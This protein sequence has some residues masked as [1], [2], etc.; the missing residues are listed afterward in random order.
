MQKI[1]ISTD[2]RTDWMAIL[3]IGIVACAATWYFASFA[4]E[5]SL[6]DGEYHPWGYDSFY[7]AAL[8]RDIVDN[9]PTTMQFDDHLHPL[10]EPAAVSFTWAYTLLLA[11][12]VVLVQQFASSL[13]TS[14]ILAYIP[15][16]WGV[17]NCLVFIALC[18]KAGLRP[19][20]LALA[21]AG[22]ALAPYTRD[23][24]MIGNVDHHFMELFFILTIMFGFYNWIESPA[25]TGRAVFS[26][27]VL[28]LSVAFHFALFVMYLPIALFF[29]ITWI[30]DR[31]ELKAAAPAFLASVLLATLIAVLPSAQFPVLK[32]E[33]FKLGWFHLYWAGVFCAAVFFL[34]RRRYTP[35]NLAI[36][37]VFLIV[38]AIPLA[39]NLL[40]GTSFLAAELPGF[41][42][43]NETR[44][45]FAYLFSGDYK[46]VKQ[47]YEYYSGLIYAV[48]FVLILLVR[49]VR[50]TP[51]PELIYTLCAF[52]LGAAFL[53]LQLRFKYH[54]SYVLL[55][56]VLLLFQQYAA[57]IRF[58][59]ALAI[60][61]F[62][63]FYAGP[64]SKLA[65]SQPPGGEP[66]YIS[67]LPFLKV[68]SKQCAAHPGILLAHPDE[69]HYLRYHTDCKILSSNML[70]ESRDFEYRALALKML[71]M[72]V[73]E[74]MRKYDWL[75]YIYARLE[76]GPGGNFDPG[77]LRSLNEGVREELLL[78]NNI[79]PGTKSL[80][81]SATP[82]FTY[83]R[84]LQVHD[85]W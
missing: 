26:G 30:S 46:L 8:V 10:H 60:I 36:L 83:Q 28:G 58:P 23:L 15:P 59:K 25:S 77:Y 55:L 16:L 51:R 45:L 27:A 12:I 38:A 11:S 56:P 85:R 75:D 3:V 43:I 78:D 79:P 35:V 44:S 42:Q 82:N 74:L 39:H 9:Y 18:R 40:H 13:P 57:E 34:L 29:L 31:M 22:F 41:D 66:G 63:V 69:G 48:P 14:T 64:V 17:I 6:I 61:A 71:G 5:A 68:V 37:A 4:I 47:V 73:E 32:F 72:S 81:S 20:A 24:H 50:L 19:L 52:L 49:Q 2:L 7:V 84:L 1:K 33:Y 62:V 67:L 54:A 70:A 65:V 53:F 80:A 76:V 21:A